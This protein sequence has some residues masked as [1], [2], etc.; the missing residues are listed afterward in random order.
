MKKASKKKKAVKVSRW[1][2]FRESRRLS[3]V[4]LTQE[5]ADFIAEQCE[6]MKCNVADFLC[7]VLAQEPKVSLEEVAKQKKPSG[8]QGLSEEAK[9]ELSDKRSK[10][11]YEREERRRQERN[12]MYGD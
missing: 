6:S 2:K 3:N 9:R 12:R 8:W 10:L 5:A 1:D 4:R 11:A 7:A